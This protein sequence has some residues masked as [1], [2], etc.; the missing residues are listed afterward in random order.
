MLST[1]LVYLLLL[2]Y[3]YL[4]ACCLPIL[5]RCKTLLNPHNELS[6]TESKYYNV[7]NDDK[8]HVVYAAKLVGWYGY[9]VM[10]KLKEEPIAILSAMV[11]WLEATNWH[12]WWLIVA[13]QSLVAAAVPLSSPSPLFSYGTLLINNINGINALY[14]CSFSTNDCSW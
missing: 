4:E 11:E 14:A 7:N 3:F 9:A 8:I 10:T 6:R 1:M 5:G 2:S 13:C 12:Q